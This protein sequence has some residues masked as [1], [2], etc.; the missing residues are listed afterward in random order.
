MSDTTEVH[1]VEPGTT[2][3]V[4]HRTAGGKLLATVGVLFA[5]L[6][7]GALIA[8]IA[9]EKSGGYEN[10]VIQDSV[11][12][13]DEAIHF[14]IDKFT[15]HGGDVRVRIQGEK[16]KASKDSY[17]SAVLLDHNEKKIGHF[18]LRNANTGS[19]EFT[20][21][22]DN[23]TLEGAYRV[24]INMHNFKGRIIVEEKK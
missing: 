1:E 7:G 23:K 6:V 15:L 19:K 18:S 12:S 10:V 21:R 22:N 20:N 17:I 9:N 2:S 16:V 4:G 8:L 13:D 24:L 5:I 14:V 3:P 11:A